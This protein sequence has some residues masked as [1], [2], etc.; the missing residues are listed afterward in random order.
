[1]V[2]GH[3][4]LT[5]AIDGLY[6]AFAGVARPHWIDVCSCCWEGPLLDD[7]V[8]DDARARV[9]AVSPGRGRPLRELTPDE[10]LDVAENVPLT[11]G[12][13]DV[14]RHYLPRLLELAVAGGFDD[15]P[16]LEVVLSH[17]SY[18]TSGDT[19]PWTT[20]PPSEQRAIREF[21]HAFWRS[22]LA[23]DDDGHQVDEALAGIGNVDADIDWY[24]AEWLRFE[25]PN[26]ARAWSASSNSTR[27]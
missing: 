6:E 17:L 21:L 20:W 2:D 12:D 22:R 5:A 9:R 10:L 8:D 25:H 27:G 15:A 4:E 14:H 26:A 24:L 23:S 13:G 1:V 16:D 18:S 19:V 7:A 11:C 3:A